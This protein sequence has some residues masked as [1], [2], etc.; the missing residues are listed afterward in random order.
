MKVTDTESAISCAAIGEGNLML[1]CLQHFSDLGICI[2]AVFT[3]SECVEKFCENSTIACYQ[4]NANLVAILKDAKIDYLFSISNPRILTDEVLKIPR[5]LTINYHDS[6]LPAYAGVHATSWAIIC[7]ERLHGISWHV[8]ESGIDTGDILQ[9]EPVDILDDDS[10]LTLNLKCVEASKRAFFRLVNDIVKDNLRPKKQPITGR[11]YF[12]LYAIPPNIGVLSFKEERQKVYN[13][14][15]GLEFGHHENAL[16]SPKIRT[17]N[18]DFFLVTNASIP[19]NYKDNEASA[20]GTIKDINGDT[21]VI[22]TNTL[23]IQVSISNLDGSSVLV[24]KFPAHK[25]L[26]GDQL[27]NSFEVSGDSIVPLRKKETFWRRKMASYEP[28][29]FYRQKMNVVASIIN[30]STEM[31]IKTVK[32]AI[33]DLKQSGFVQYN[34]DFLMSSFVAFVARISC[35]SSV[36]LGLLTDKSYIPVSCQ[37]LYSDVLP[38]IFHVEHQS[39]VK[40]VFESCLKEI[41][42]YNTALTFL[43]DMFYRYPEL[44]GHKRTPHH[45]IVLGES[46]FWEIS[47]RTRQEILRDCNVLLLFDHTK[48]EIEVM[49][50][51]RPA[52]DFSYI[53]DRLQHFATFLNVCENNDSIQLKYISM[54][55]EDEMKRFYGL[56]LKQESDINHETIAKLVDRQCTLTPLGIALKTTDHVTTYSKLTDEINN[57]CDVLARAIPRNGRSKPIV[58]LHMPNSISYV[59]CVN[60]IAKCDMAFLPLPINYPAERLA[61][62]IKDARVNNMIITKEIFE[63]CDMNGLTQRMQVVEVCKIANETVVLVDFGM[64]FEPEN[65]NNQEDNTD[66]DFIYLM[67]TSGSTG[68]PKG[69]KVKESG[70]INLARAQITCWDIAPGDV[71]AQFASI[72]FDATISEIFI[73]LLSGACLAVLGPNERLGSEFVT[74]MNKMKISV[75]TLP[76]SALNIYSP[77]GLPFLRKVVTAG[78]ACTLNTAVKWTSAANVRFFNAYGPTEATVCAT[79]YEYFPGNVYEDVNRD[80]PIGKAIDGV[81]VYIFDDFMNPIPPDVVGEL[82]IGGKGLAHGYMGHAKHFT[83]ERFVQNPLCRE[84]MLLYKTGDHAFQDRDGNLTYIGRT[85]D[86]VK[87]RGHRIDLSEIEQ[88]LIQHAMIEMAIVVVHKCSKTNEMSIA[89]YVCPAFVYI[90][91]LREYLQKVIPLYMIPSYIK[92]L[93]VHDLPKNLNGKVNRK[94]LEI[95]ESIHVQNESVGHSHLNETQLTI[96][97]LWCKVLKLDESFMYSLHR[98]SSFRELGGNSLQLVLLL[99]LIEEE[100]KMTISFTHLGM[101]DTIEEFS[102][103]IRRRRDIKTKN[104]HIDLRSNA[105]LRELIFHDS[106]LDSSFFPY[107]ER[108][109]SVEGA[110]DTTLMHSSSSKKHPKNILISGVTG[111]LGAFLLSE[112]LEQTNSNVCCLVRESTETRGIGRIIDNLR[113]YGLWKFEYSIRIAVVISD[114]SQQNLGIASDIY[115]ELCNVVDVVFMNAAVM[116]FNKPYEDHRIENVESTKEFIKFAS[117]GVQKYLFATSSLSVFLFPPDKIHNGSHRRICTEAEF[118]DD[119]L[120]IIG[121]YGQSKWAS[122]R[123]VKQALDFLPGGAI[124]RPARISGRST[125]GNGPKNDLFASIMYGMK[126]MG[127]FPDIDFPFD[128]TPVDFC[129]K[130]MTEVALNI[131]TSAPNTYEKVYHIFNKD[132]VSFG[133]LFTGM[134]LQPV[135][136]EEWRRKLKQ[137]NVD[138]KELL[139]LTPFLMSEFWDHASDWPTFDTS[140]LDKAISD[141]TKQFLHPTKELLEI[142]KTYFRL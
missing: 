79:C 84:P 118:F 61:F 94:K 35:T 116:N 2:K 56:P 67:Y 112:I 37:Y 142:C 42:S 139:S 24:G 7:S 10:A 36:H 97:R 83:K 81:Q 76:P 129:A 111:F 1:S 69:V 113:K 121:G 98:K 134:E 11:T 133:D 53:I 87:I 54:V 16:G 13:L 55:T 119:P 65:N 107:S 114:L 123:L 120:H 63:K 90:S 108:R 22:A 136:L 131:C 6:P 77:E 80:L 12:G 31:N 95:D 21:L 127:S 106:E 32:I 78:E 52:Q 30:V 125:D 45:N 140:N 86:Q 15:R 46:G 49:Y 66:A 137:V 89:A 101:A 124:F 8:V 72:G 9:S 57:L 38:A 115:N 39:T 28:T 64:A 51:K 50:H 73:A 19:L 130:A 59:V 18:G 70:V 47:E 62:T 20:P 26:I 96:A 138:N 82:Y 103:F 60:A 117:T 48:S 68:R 74:A 91:E 132:T 4:R 88:V 58:A 43:N 102:E 100:I 23:P 126:K 99:R 128:L 85:D 92:K 3:N 141:K 109:R 14:A 33:P 34:N 93:D 5:K 104:E 25:L 29:M 135:P 27:D 122:E 105:D 40:D 17:S 110:H 71:V 44:R 75:I 41:N